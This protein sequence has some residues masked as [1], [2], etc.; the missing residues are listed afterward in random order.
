MPKSI[1]DIPPLILFSD[2]DQKVANQDFFQT[3]HQYKPVVMYDDPFR[4]E[5]KGKLV[6]C[7]SPTRQECKMIMDHY[8]HLEPWFGMEQEYVLF[9]PKTNRPLGWPKHGVPE[10]QVNLIKLD[11]LDEL[12]LTIII[13]K[14]LL[15]SRSRKSIW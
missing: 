12:Y 11:K 8:A 6:L 2:D 1:Q 15:W 5:E 7:E 9:D 3:Q 10:S 14:I 4:V 13:G